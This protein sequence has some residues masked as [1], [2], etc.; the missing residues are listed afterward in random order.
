MTGVRFAVISAWQGHKLQLFER[1]RAGA[2][3]CLKKKK[4]NYTV[5]Q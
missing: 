1:T 5:C 3:Q 2:F 4:N